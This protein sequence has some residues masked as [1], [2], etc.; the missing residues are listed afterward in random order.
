MTEQA[1]LVIRIPVPVPDPA[2]EVLDHAGKFIAG[3]ALVVAGL[4]LAQDFIPAEAHFFIVVNMITMIA[5]CIF[6]SG[7]DDLL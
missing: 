1:K 3:I 7:L 4:E 6:Y 5:A 2:T